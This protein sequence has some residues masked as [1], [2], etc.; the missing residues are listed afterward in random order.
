MEFN[1]VE[2]NYRKWAAEKQ[3]IDRAK[4]V[5]FCNR[6]VGKW[7]LYTEDSNTFFKML[8]ADKFQDCNVLKI[9]YDSYRNYEIGIIHHIDIDCLDLIPNS[10]LNVKEF[11]KFFA[12]LTS[13]LTPSPVTERK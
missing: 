13:L 11:G 4:M 1:E 3:K 7:F 6:N 2:D 10:N 9:Y 12:L 8:P 5:D